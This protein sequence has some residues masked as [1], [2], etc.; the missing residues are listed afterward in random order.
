VRLTD[1]GVI[2]RY[3]AAWLLDGLRQAGADPEVHFEESGA[4]LRRVALLAPGAEFSITRSSENCADVNAMGH[5]HRTS[6]PPPGDYHALREELAVSG[7]DPVFERALTGA[8]SLV[9]RGSK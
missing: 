9:Y 5:T 2:S 8:H 6:L 3:L 7:A 1:A 4:R